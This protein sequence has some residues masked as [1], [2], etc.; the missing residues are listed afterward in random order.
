M[1]GKA[2]VDFF[3]QVKTITSNWSPKSQGKSA[4]GL[5]GVGA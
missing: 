4:S 3:T 2:A 5:H 1:Y